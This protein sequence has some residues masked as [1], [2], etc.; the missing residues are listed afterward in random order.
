MKVMLSIKPQFVEKIFNGDKKF[1]YRKVIFKNKDIKTVVVYSTMPVG[2]IIGEFDIDN[3]LEGHPST[4][5]DKTKEFSG[6]NS[7]FYHDYFLG[8]KKGFAIEIKSLNKYDT[9][10]CPYD[11]YENFTAP[12]SFKYINN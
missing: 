12:Q 1:E 10:I 8:R 7:E 6:V 2:K 9:P 5:W 3:I 4:L 11:K